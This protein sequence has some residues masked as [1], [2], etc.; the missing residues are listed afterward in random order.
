MVPRHI[1]TYDAPLE[2]PGRTFMGTIFYLIL[3]LVW[4]S[5]RRREKNKFRWAP[6]VLTSSARQSVGRRVRPRDQRRDG[7]IRGTIRIGVVRILHLQMQGVVTA[8]AASAMP[9]PVLQ[10]GGHAAHKWLIPTIVL[11]RN[12]SRATLKSRFGDKPAKYE[13]GCPQGG[14]AVQ[15][16]LRLPPSETRFEG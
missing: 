11:E 16:G 6:T 8:L 12:P 9:L 10:L 15:K 5:F 2:I 13:V 14:A 4:D 1:N 7:V 3:F